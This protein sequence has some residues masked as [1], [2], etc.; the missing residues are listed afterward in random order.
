MDIPETWKCNLES[1]FGS[2]SRGVP[3][4]VIF[5]AANAG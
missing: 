5:A 4:Q 2:V 1:S 3:V